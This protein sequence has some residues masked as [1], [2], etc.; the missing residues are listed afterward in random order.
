MHSGRTPEEMACQVLNDAGRDKAA[1]WDL[2]FRP[3]NAAGEK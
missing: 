1:A 2:V 3:V